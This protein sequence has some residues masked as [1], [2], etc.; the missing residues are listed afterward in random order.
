[1]VVKNGT[2]EVYKD[3]KLIESASVNNGKLAYTGSSNYVIFGILAVAIVALVI[4]CVMR[5]R[6]VHA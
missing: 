5:K 2:V 1:M 6:K 4:V 3:G